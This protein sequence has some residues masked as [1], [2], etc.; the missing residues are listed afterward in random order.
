M[1]GR[2][3]ADRL[4]CQSLTPLPPPA[5]G[6]PSPATVVQAYIRQRFRISIDCA[7]LSRVSCGLWIADVS[8]VK[9]RAHPTPTH[10]YLHAPAHS[11]PTPTHQVL[12][13]DGWNT[14]LPAL[15]AVAHPEAT[16]AIETSAQVPVMVPPQDAEGKKGPGGEVVERE[17]EVEDS[18]PSQVAVATPRR[19]P[20]RRASH[21]PVADAA[22]RRRLQ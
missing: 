10:V 21:T 11:L 9:V 19:N 4:H 20:K 12:E 16:A 5:D 7:R 18:P 22:A 3:R 8:A 15:F 14:L 2:A 13:G 17:D 6:A 1:R